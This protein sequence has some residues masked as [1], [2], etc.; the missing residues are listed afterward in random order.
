VVSQQS[1]D[2]P[3]EQ[4]PRNAVPVD[5]AAVVAG[6]LAARS[7]VFQAGD[8]GR[9]GEVYADGAIAA[10]GD[11]DV[12]LASGPVGVRYDVAGLEVI[13]QTPERAT[14]DVVVRAQPTGRAGTA[15]VVA[16]DSTVSL[17]LVRTGA[18]WR[19]ASVTPLPDGQVGSGGVS[20]R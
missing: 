12:L 7:D 20:P 11:H 14:V 4:S 8:A 6:L 18:G 16:G 17:L 1:D 10:V 9:L 19:I 13:E 5:V 3:G 2:V 15:S